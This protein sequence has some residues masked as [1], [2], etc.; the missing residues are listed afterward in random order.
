MVYFIFVHFFLLKTVLIGSPIM[1]WHPVFS[2][3]LGYRPVD[4]H[5]VVKLYLGRYATCVGGH[6]RQLWLFVWPH[7]ALTAKILTAKLDR[8]IDGVCVFVSG[9]VFLSI[10]N[11]RGRRLRRATPRGGEAYLKLREQPISA[12]LIPYPSVNPLGILRRLNLR[13]VAKEIIT[14]P[15]TIYF[16][17]MCTN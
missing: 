2:H 3:P 14:R 12:V 10:K 4:D 15:L 9:H 13:I 16:E 11:P 17:T 8:H 6:Q 1:H 5:P 7:E